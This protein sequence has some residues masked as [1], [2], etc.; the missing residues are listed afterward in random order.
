MK[1]SAFFPSGNLFCI[2]AAT[3]ALLFGN[4]P[5]AQTP[6]WKP[7]A[8]LDLTA[9][10][11]GRTTGHIATLT[12]SNLSDKPITAELGPFFIPTFNKY[13]PYIVPAPAPVNVPPFTTINIPLTGFCADIHRP[14]V[15]EGEAMPPIQSW[16]KPA[17]LASTWTPSP[18]KGWTPL[19]ADFCIS[20]AT[21]QASALNCLLPAIPG[22]DTPLSHSINPNQHPEEAAPLLMEGISRITAAY[23]NMRKE[24]LIA[25]PFSQNM[26][27]E[28]ES[29][30]QQT[31][32]IYCAGLTGQEYKVEDFRQN[33]IK[34]FESS[35]GRDFEKA[36]ADVRQN[37]DQGVDD[38]W[39][40]FQAVGVEAKVLAMNLD[41]DED[42]DVDYDKIE[43][44]E[45][46]PKLIIPG[47]DR[48][49]T[50]RAI[51][52]KSHEEAMKKAFSSD[53]ARKRWSEVFKRIYGK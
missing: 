34:Q 41:A 14:P 4:T 32:W 29:V 51:N 20:P 8:G 7:P 21:G 44:R 3:G 10:G 13:Q 26:E 40:T 9:R 2:V 11:T 37:I 12:V 22:A 39:N 35:T 15:P 25:T 43:K 16:V 48:Y 38:F 36:P 52:G 24:G 53:K 46:L 28:R 33:T 50:E 30:I 27:K 42:E 45:Q 19:P 1:R 47:Y 49:T 23:D 6:G 17:P 31:F 5:Q 18:D